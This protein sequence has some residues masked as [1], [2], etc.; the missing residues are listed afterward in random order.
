MLCFGENV[1]KCYIKGKILYL[2]DFIWCFF[3]FRCACQ[4]TCF[5][6][7]TSEIVHSGFWSLIKLTFIESC[8]AHLVRFGFLM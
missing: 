2:R 1:E 4:T 8:V 6:V 7:Y 3:F 5:F